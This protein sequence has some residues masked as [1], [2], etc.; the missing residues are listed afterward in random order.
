[1]KAE[2]RRTEEE[3]ARKSG[4]AGQETAQAQAMAIAEMINSP[5]AERTLSDFLGGDED[6]P[7]QPAE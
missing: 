5:Q 3:T 2:T 1:M 6:D 7:L 4:A